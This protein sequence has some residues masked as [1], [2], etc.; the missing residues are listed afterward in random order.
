MSPLPHHSRKMAGLVLCALLSAC[1][2]TT[3]VT[4]APPNQAPICQPQKDLKVSV[5]WRTDWRPDQ[6]DVPEREAAASQGIADF[7]SDSKCFKSTT[8][9]RAPSGN[10][11]NSGPAVPQKSDLLLVLT[12]RELGPTV[13]LFSSAALIEGGT[14]VSVDVALY[15]PAKAEPE[16]RFSILWRDAGAGVV[17]GVKS[18][19]EDMTA[20]L[21]AGL[22][23]K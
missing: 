9:A 1:A 17:K 13:K 16:R 3:T 6:K 15:A 23:A 14:E 2:A 10:S 18:L 22:H 21:K 8:V 20:A 12:V 5:L 7:F 11:G 19:P 4:L